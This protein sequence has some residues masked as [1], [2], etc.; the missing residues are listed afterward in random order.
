[1]N[2]DGAKKS[3]GRISS[4]LNR[5]YNSTYHCHFIV[6]CGDQWEEAQGNGRVMMTTTE[7][8]T[9][10]TPRNTEWILW[11]TGLFPTPLMNIWKILAGILYLHSVMCRQRSRSFET[12]IVL[13]ITEI[14]PS[15]K[16]WS[17]RITNK[18]FTRLIPVA[19]LVSGVQ[20][21]FY[22]LLIILLSLCFLILK[23]NHI[24]QNIIWSDKCVMNVR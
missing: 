4:Q 22:N 10:T 1:M 6:Q 12:I 11:A 15:C 3:L 7:K 16:N 2:I 9:L 21:I 14:C 8:R 23:D 5:V 19:Y 13:Y 24:W 18:N 17:C 20:N